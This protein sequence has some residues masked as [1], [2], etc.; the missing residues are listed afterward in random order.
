MKFL[1][2]Q[3]TILILSVIFLY[4]LTS[5]SY[6]LPYDVDGSINWYSVSTV[7]F[8]IFLISQSL[9]SLIIFIFQKYL[10]YGKKEFPDFRSSLKWGIGLSLSLVVA[11][12]LNIFHILTI[13]IGIIVIIL[14]I[15]AISIL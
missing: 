1:I 14:V 11:I 6:F 3:L 13:Q 8:L 10:A 9:I 5:L 2:S 15:I 7:L 12:L 4:Y